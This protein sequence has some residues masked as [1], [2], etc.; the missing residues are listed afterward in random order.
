MENLT[1]TLIQVDILKRWYCI[2]S[3]AAA[4]L[5]LHFKYD[6]K[7]QTVTLVAIANLSLCMSMQSN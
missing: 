1:P 7:L 3:I 2:M 5:L 6:W 4:I